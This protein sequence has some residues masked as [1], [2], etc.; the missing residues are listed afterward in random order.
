MIEF[1]AKFL[2]IEKGK[3]RALLKHKG[4]RLVRPE[5]SQKRFN[6]HLP[7][8]K[9]SNDAWLRVRN[10][11]DRITLA[12]KMITGSSIED[13]K[14]IQLVIDSFDNAITLLESIGCEKKA[15]QE[16]RRELWKLG[17]TEITIDEW[18]GLEPFVEI[19]GSSE[20]EVKNPIDNSIRHTLEGGLSVNLSRKDGKIL[21]FVKDTGVGLSEELKPKLFTQGGRDKN[22]IKININS[23]GF[24]LSF[25]KCVVE[26][27][28]G[29][30]WAESDG[31]NKG[32]TFYMELPVI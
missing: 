18:P 6:F 32:S 5:Y 23:T 7:K 25:V 26:A 9:R 12:L 20:D 2:D 13:Q 22:S 19:E 24:G 1:E 21:F 27:H 28:K 8:D 16:S 14:E 31:P 15:F 4:A 3:I 29:R 11:G 30:V 17:Q 10:E